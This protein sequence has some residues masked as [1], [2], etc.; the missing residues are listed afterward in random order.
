MN[1]LTTEDRDFIIFLRNKAE[2]LDSNIIFLTKNE[3]DHYNLN[4]NSKFIMCFENFKKNRLI[5][6]INFLQD[7][8]IFYNMEN[9]F[10]E[11]SFK[12]E[13]DSVKNVVD[14]SIYYNK[15]I[16]SVYGNVM[17]LDFYKNEKELVA[18]YTKKDPKVFISQLDIISS[19]ENL[20]ADEM[21]LKEDLDGGFYLIMEINLDVI[22]NYLNNKNSNNSS[23]FKMI[24]DNKYIINKK[25]IEFKGDINSL[26]IKFFYNNRN[27]Y[28][29]SD[30]MM[31]DF[32]KEKI[33]KAIGQ[34]NKRTIEV[35][36]LELIEKKEIVPG[37]KNKGYEYICRM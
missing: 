4:N 25:G 34:I 16:S 20:Y 14:Y 17:D 15:Y 29:S 35:I 36:G 1:L 18:I 9:I 23:V 12:L 13:D 33:R 31:L 11:F 32:N 37:S 10:R 28:Y 26:I 22:D 6:K 3:F 24:N 30:K 27:T 8:Y 7:I 2:R 5:K 21:R 19:D